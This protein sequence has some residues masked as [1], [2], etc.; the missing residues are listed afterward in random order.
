MTPITLPLM[1]DAGVAFRDSPALTGSSIP[2]TLTVQMETQSE[3][4]YFLSLSVQAGLGLLQLLAN[5]P[6]IQDYLS[7]QESSEPPKRQ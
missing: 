6:P 3:Q 2:P 7:G 1:V 5:W 4:I